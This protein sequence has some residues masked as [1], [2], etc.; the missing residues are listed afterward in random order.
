M[1]PPDLFLF[2]GEPSGDLH[3][4][5]LLKALLQ[6]NPG[7]KII[8]VGGPK[9]RNHPFEVILPME[10]FQVMGFVDVFLSLP[11]LIRQFYF[12]KRTI[13]ERQPKKV[14]LIDYPGFNLRLARSLRTSG[15]KG[16]ICH[17][18]CPSVW[19][20]GKKRIPLMA[21]HLDLLLSILPFEAKIF[22]QTPLQVCYIGNPLVNHIESHEPTPLPELGEG[23]V[24]GIFPGSRTKEIDRN[25]KM[26]LYC[27]RRLLTLDPTLTV[28]LSVSHPRFCSRMQ[29][30]CSEAGISPHFIP[31]DYTYD[32]MHR[33]HL[34]L[35]TSGTVTLEL[36]LHGVPTVVTYGIST[37]DL[38]IA[39]HI[40]R[41]ILPYYCLVNII[42]NQEIFPELIG[43]NL[44]DDSLFE[45]ASLFLTDR[46]RRNAALQA[47]ASIRELLSRKNAS[48]EAAKAIASL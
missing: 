8:G 28:A 4:D 15:F 7:L 21:E 18:I 33:C 9:M 41:I 46:T 10:A 5:E 38:I 22:A 30:I 24:L 32:L 37:L 2:A 16:K 29:Q 39:K 42:A 19:A 31:H 36:A 20:W 13:L 47:C 35:A 17:Y 6:N 25:L 11:K 23:K 27:A 48:H 45:K 43:P 40:L 12:V 26:Q 44:K 1:T 34:A 3:G 14:V